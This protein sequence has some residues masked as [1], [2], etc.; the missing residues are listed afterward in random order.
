MTEFQYIVLIALATI[1][2]SY[3][4]V[5]RVAAAIAHPARLRM[6]DLGR[7]LL[8]SPRLS[9]PQKSLVDSMLDDAFDWRILIALTIALPFFC[10]VLVIRRKS[11]SVFSGIDDVEL[12]RDIHEFQKC[13][14]KAICAANPLFA[15]LF[16]LELPVLFL[17][18][19]A[20]RFRD[21][22][23]VAMEG[24]DSKLLHS[25]NRT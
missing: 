22:L 18:A 15:L 10:V 11:K 3:P 13:Y 2:V 6:A 17:F 20:C 21:L 9:E 7:K 24:V 14:M 16:L 12:A 4:I 8:A 1:V 19:K 5:M 25:P 23:F